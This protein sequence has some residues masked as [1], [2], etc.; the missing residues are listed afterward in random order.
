[1]KLYWVEKGLAGRMMIL[2][3]ASFFVLDLHHCAFTDVYTKNVFI[4]ETLRNRKR[5]VLEE[6]QELSEE[7]Y[8]REKS[9]DDGLP[10]MIKLAEDTTG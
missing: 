3:C 1:M 5:Q 9:L 8:K 2:Y 6:E 10:E 7:D 4:V